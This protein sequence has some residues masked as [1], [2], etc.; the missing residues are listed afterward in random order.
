MLPTVEFPGRI[1]LEEEIWFQIHWKNSKKITLKFNVC[2]RHFIHWEI[3]ISIYYYYLT[4]IILSNAHVSVNKIEI[5]FLWGLH[6]ILG[7]GDKH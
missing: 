7:D 3:L 1:N 5:I 4:N 6:W 2:I